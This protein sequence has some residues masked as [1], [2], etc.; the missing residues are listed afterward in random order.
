MWKIEV[1]EQVGQVE[2]FYLRAGSDPSQAVALAPIRDSPKVSHFYAYIYTLR[3]Q[4]HWLQP[5]GY[6]L[7]SRLHVLE[8]REHKKY[9][10]A[11]I[12][13]Q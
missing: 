9:P 10:L 7:K 13:D 8:V 5:T 2:Q 11:T 3:P 6:R 1:E 12:T 4:N